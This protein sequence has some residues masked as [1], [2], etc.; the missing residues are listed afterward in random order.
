MNYEEC[1]AYFEQLK[2][3]GYV[4]GLE[5]MER[6]LEAMGHPERRPTVHVAGTNGKGSV[7]NYVEKVLLEAGYKVGKYTSPA[8]RHFRD[9]IVVNEVPITE[10]EV[11]EQLTAIRE[12]CERE[13]I[14]ITEFEAM[15]LLAFSH[16]AKEEAEILVLEVGMGGRLDATNAIPT[17]TVACVTNIGLDHCQYL[18]NTL[19]EIAGEKAGIIKEGGRVVLYDLPKTVREV[20][21]KKA[22]SVGAKLRSADFKQIHVEELFP[23]GA[24]F[25]YKNWENLEIPMAGRHQIRNAVTALEVLEELEEAG[26]PNLKSLRKGFKRATLECRLEYLEMG[27]GIFL[28][29]GHNPQGVE[30]VVKYFEAAFPEDRLFVV[31]GT[32]R[33]KEY[34]KNLAMLDRIAKTYRFVTLD[35]YRALDAGVLQD[36]TKVPSKVCSLEEAVEEALHQKRKVLICGSFYLAYPARERLQEVRH[37][38]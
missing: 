16:F 35:S 15:T 4:L 30:E 6:A 28:D 10:E 36:L 21:E 32:L 38:K 22:E 5:N 18:G 12:L 25:S 37:V 11:A 34:E 24:E 8:I 17:P 20:F 1:M 29:G 13:E 27:P 14:P 9:R 31:Y 2:L 26:I 7:C 33:D 3:R 23:G 19:E